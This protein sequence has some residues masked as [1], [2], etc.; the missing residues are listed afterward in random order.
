MQM[1]SR[2]RGTE[3]KIPKFALSGSVFPITE[4]VFQGCA[5][6]GRTRAGCL[7]VF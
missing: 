3:W 7:F 1:P 4:I 6:E 2:G 5:A